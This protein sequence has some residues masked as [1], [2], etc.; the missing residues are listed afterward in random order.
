MSQSPINPHPAGLAGALPV[1]PAAGCL[2]RLGFAARLVL[3]ASRTW[4]TDRGA[5]DGSARHLAQAFRLARCRPALVPFD[6]VMLMAV[7]GACRPVV[8]AARDAEL[9]R[10]ESALLRAVAAFQDDAVVGGERALDA[11]LPAATARLAAD[12]ALRLA[13]ALGRAGLYIRPRGRMS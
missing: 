9:T 7:H 6:E 5:H 3:W 2:A 1:Q 10:D 8:F 4:N 11:W 13:R 12:P